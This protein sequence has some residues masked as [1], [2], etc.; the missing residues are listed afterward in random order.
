MVKE[1]KYYDVLGVA[2]NASESEL[3]KA[4]RKLALKYHPDKNPEGGEQFKLISQV[5]LISRLIFWYPNVLCEYECSYYRVT[6]MAPGIMQQ[7]NTVCSFCKGSGDK[8]SM[9]DRCKSCLGNKK[10]IKDSR[11]VEEILEVHIEKG[12]HDGQRIMFEGRGDEDHDLPPGNI[13]IVLEEKDHNTFLRKDDNLVINIEIQVS[14]LSSRNILS[15]LGIFFISYT[16]VDFKLVEALCG[17]SRTI[18]TLDNRTL[19]FTVLPGEVIKHSDIKVIHGEG[20]PFRKNPQEKGDLLVQFKVEFPKVLNADCR[21]KLSDLLPDKTL[22]VVDDDADVFDLEEISP[23][24][25]RRQQS[26]EG[27]EGGVRC[28]HQ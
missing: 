15:V 22:A 5:L 6:H 24:R 17:F 10:V 3:K 9:K 4:Y 18:K 28:Q 27:E 12:M 13:I 1:T 23:S 14:L 2:P 25:S 20:M 19:F 11:K 21:R 16:I 7:M 26:H 8:I